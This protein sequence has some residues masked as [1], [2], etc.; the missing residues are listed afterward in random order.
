MNF[1]DPIIDQL[2]QRF[3]PQLADDFERYRNHVQRVYSFC[4]LL[5]A[6]AESQGL[7]AIAAVF[8]DIGIWTEH[9]FDYLDP[10]LAQVQ[11]YLRESGCETWSEEISNMIYW[12]HKMS[13]YRG[14]HEKTVETFRKADWIDVSL[15][16]M[17]FGLKK[18]A[19]GFI[20][21]QFP[22]K[23]FHRFLVKQTL[24]NLLR[25]PWNPLP[26]FKR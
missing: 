13:R 5:D 8:H 22:N 24:R 7:Y 15:G 20:Q 18:Q 3:A 21:N 26:M 4:R 10:S 19:I 11:A 14:A 17:R 25:Q 12:H 23:G 16:F 9:T 1:P 6:D 2:L